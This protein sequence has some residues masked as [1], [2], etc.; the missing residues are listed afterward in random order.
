MNRKALPYPLIWECAGFVS[1]KGESLRAA[2]SV[3]AAGGAAGEAERTA[4]PRD[5]LSKLKTAYLERGGMPIP[6]KEDR[7]LRPQWQEG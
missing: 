1:P 4:L 6:L 7:P 5:T 3:V 2:G